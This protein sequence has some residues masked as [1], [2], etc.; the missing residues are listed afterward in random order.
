MKKKELIK[1]I[2]HLEN[3]V[4][5][6]KQ[7][8]ALSECELTGEDIDELIDSCNELRHPKSDM[9]MESQFAKG[10]NYQRFTIGC[11]DSPKVGTYGE[12]WN[13]HHGLSE[14]GL[15]LIYVSERSR[16]HVVFTTLVIPKPQALNLFKV[17]S[18][19]IEELI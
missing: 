19:N 14:D 17:L 13:G 3:Q 11:L 1:R 8:K 10:I 6:N 5:F 18:E 9:I 12:Q 16:E 7:I 15:E 4:E 2:K